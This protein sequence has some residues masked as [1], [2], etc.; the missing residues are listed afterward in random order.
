[1]IRRITLPLPIVVVIAALSTTS[2]SSG[3]TK[4]DAGSS[5]IEVLLKERRDALKESVLL[6]WK[7]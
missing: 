1:M 6:D 7:F 4:A 3:Q 5:K 2:K